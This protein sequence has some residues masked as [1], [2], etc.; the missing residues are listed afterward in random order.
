MRAGSLPSPGPPEPF[1]ATM[2]VGFG[3]WR[4][5]WFDLPLA[6]L[7]EVDR[8][9]TAVAMFGAVPDPARAVAVL[10]GCDAIRGGN[11]TR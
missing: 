9:A 8:A 5:F 10:L 1:V 11:S 2:E 6:W 4:L 3:L 7:A